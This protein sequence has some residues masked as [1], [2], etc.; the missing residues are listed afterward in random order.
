MQSNGKKVAGIIM[1]AIGVIFLL[2]TVSVCGS[3]LFVEK[4]IELSVEQMEDEMDEFDELESTDGEIVYMDGNSDYSYGS[5]SYTEIGFYTEDGDYY[6]FSVDAYS[7]DYD[8]GDE[9]EVYYDA[10]NPRN[11]FAPELLEGIIDGI[12]GVFGLVG[13]IV[14]IVFGLI[15]L[16]FIIGGI[17]LLKGNRKTYDN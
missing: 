10:E 2:V 12:S 13:K 11:A 3:F 5:D 17:V 15:S 16:A 9:I 14:G 8:E 4:M 6:E 7:S 1:I